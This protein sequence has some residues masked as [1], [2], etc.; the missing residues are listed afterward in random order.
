MH[1]Q[2]HFKNNDSRIYRKKD[3]R[4]IETIKSTNCETIIFYTIFFLIIFIDV[5]FKKNRKINFVSL[6][7]L[8]RIEIILKKKSYFFHTFFFCFLE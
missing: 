8:W 4:V 2:Q 7:S 3:S 5:K 6:V 1:S